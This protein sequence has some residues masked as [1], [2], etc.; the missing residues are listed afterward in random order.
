MSFFRRTAMAS[1]GVL[2][3]AVAATASAQ[4]EPVLKQIDLPHSYYYREMYLPQLTSGP[5]SVAWS[6]DGESLVYSMAGSLWRQKIGTELAVELT[7]GP[8]YDYQPDWS[9]DGKLIVF[10][11]HHNNAIELWQLDVAS[12]AAQQLTTTDAVNLEPRYSPDG[13]RLAYVSTAG[14]GHFN[15]FVA[16]L[17]GAKLGTPRAVVAA[18]ESKIARYYY[19]KHDHTINPSWTPDG[20][21]LLFVS[22]R[23]IAYGTGDACSA[24]ADGTGEVKCFLHEETSWRA[25]P[26]VAPDGRRVLYSSYQ[27]RQW[28]Q[29]WLTTL[30]GDAQLPLT[31]GDFDATAA[32]WSPDGRRIAYVSNED[33]NVSLWVLDAVGGERTRIVAREQQYARPMATLRIQL[34]GAGRISVLGADDRYYG[35]RDRWM[36]ADDGFDPVRVPSEVRYFH[37]PGEC[38][39]TV[40]V[41]ETYVTAWRGVEHTPVRQRVDTQKGSANSVILALQPLQLP[42]WAPRSV[43]A[44]LHVHMNYGGHYR[45]TEE[46]LIEQ[47][48]AEDLDVIYN[49]IV[50]KE[51]R[52]PDIARF[53]PATRRDAS[54]I[55]IFRNQEY[56]TSYWGHLGLLHLQRYLTPDFSAY[57]HS[58]LTS[59]YPHNGVIADLVHKQG[60]LVGYVHPFDTVPVPETESLTNAMP[61]DVALNKTDYIEVVG[62]A[63]HKATAEVWYKLL[64]L[65]FRVPT[66]SGTDAMANYASLRGPVG[67][68]RVYLA[69]DGNVEPAALKSALKEG[70]TFATNGPQLALDVA[71]NAPGAT[72]IVPAGGQTVSYRAALRSPVAIDHFELVQNGR[73]VARHR[74]GKGRTQADVSGKLKLTQSGWIVLRAWNDA[75]D[76]LILDLYPYAT[77]SPV[78]VSVGGAA[79]N[80][81]ADAQYFVHW[82]DRTI[83]AAAGRTDYNDERERRETLEYLQAA[84]AVYVQKAQQ[85]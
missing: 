43:S 61:V 70:R 46:N 7:H 76:P 3:L 29:L 8:G 64:N 48:R 80:S 83:A 82:L 5:S 19:S 67:M 81:P 28:H 36:H 73:V 65:G 13:K 85:Q 58:A 78:Y 49:L 18:H 11:R 25:R 84:R 21:R 68:N 38:E 4:R 52:I 57:Q 59:P 1:I 74:L 71:G 15:L 55:T 47:A 54:G 37:C 31:F 53:D 42:D 26:E 34:N 40:P 32:R 33:G 17:D 6:P 77:T 23:E 51:Q 66:G 50:N 69:T 63:D 20:E 9:P 62:F 22:N 27:G 41:G 10:A 75:A 24:A 60:G 16:P 39:V 79:T 2:A 14:S 72:M 45:N 56:H 35:P 30:A 12:G 44:D